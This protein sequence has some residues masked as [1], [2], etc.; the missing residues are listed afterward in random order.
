[1]VFSGGILPENYYICIMKKTRK[2]TA[3][4]T[5]ICTPERKFILNSM[6]ASFRIEGISIPEPRVMAI[7]ERVNEKLKK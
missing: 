4:L 5:P 3:I 2:N 1:M 7:Y 6:I